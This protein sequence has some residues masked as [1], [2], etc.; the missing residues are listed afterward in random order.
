MSRPIFEGQSTKEL[1]IP[2]AI[3][4][5]NYTMNSVDTA[6]QLRRGFTVHQPGESK[7]WR[8]IFYF[9][10][11]ICCNNTYLI[12]KTRW[13]PKNH[14]LHQLFEDELETQLLQYDL[15]TPRPSN[16]FEHEREPLPTK[17]QC[18]YGLKVKGGCVQG[19][20]PR[21]M[22]RTVL[23][24]IKPNARPNPKPR[25]VRWGCKQCRVPLCKEGTCWNKYHS[26]E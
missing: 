13:S 18:A 10:I 6:S 23:G 9:L 24:E 5:Y 21:G 15:H 25:E 1:R 14:K 19:G 26:T 4:D 11:D 7:W 8:P 12:W 3:D 20:T 16:V 22:K 17:L 2:K